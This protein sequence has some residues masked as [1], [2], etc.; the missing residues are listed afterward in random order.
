MPWT[1]F[2]KNRYG[3]LFAGVNV[4]IAGHTAAPGDTGAN[5]LAGH[6]Y[7]RGVIAPGRMSVNAAG[8]I[9]IDQDIEI[10]TPNDDDAQD[11]TRFSFWD[12]IAA[13]NLLV[14]SDDAIANIAV[15]VNGQ[16]VMLEAGSIINT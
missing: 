11:I 1:N 13:G 4:Y 12:A 9:S 10:Y 15:P 7:S 14:Y 3:N 5:E 16:P 8:V 2:S 6:G